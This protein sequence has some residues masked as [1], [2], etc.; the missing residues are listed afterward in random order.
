MAKVNKRRK[1]LKADG[2]EGMAT[3]GK[4]VG[5]YGLRIR[6]DCRWLLR[7]MDLCRGK[8]VEGVRV[9]SRGGRK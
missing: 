5:R 1:L 9:E 4:W 2:R 3:N 8:Q 6:I 7:V